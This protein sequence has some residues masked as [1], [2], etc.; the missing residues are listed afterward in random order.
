MAQVQAVRA[1]P[2]AR[3]HA[4]VWLMASSG[5][6]GGASSRSMPPE[7]AV[8]NLDSPRVRAAMRVLGVVPKDL[9][10]KSKDAFESEIRWEFFEQKRRT[11]IDSVMALHDESPEGHT[12]P[13]SAE[14]AKQAEEA[15]MATV[16]ENERKAV[17]VMNRISR[18]EVQKT[19]IK[20]LEAQHQ[21]HISKTKQEEGRK[22]QLALEKERD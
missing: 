17:E 3:A 7:P 6:A 2:C 12:I 1:H 19:M 14:K 22:R 9:Q 8:P 16:M 20:E 15:L 10:K 11:I 4:E 18:K 13:D 5:G 21:A